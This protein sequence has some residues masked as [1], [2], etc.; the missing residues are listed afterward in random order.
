MA[1]GDA[2]E[3]ETTTGGSAALARLVAIDFI[4]MFIGAF[5]AEVVVFFFLLVAS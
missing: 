3:G 1:F 5:L 4:V 2:A